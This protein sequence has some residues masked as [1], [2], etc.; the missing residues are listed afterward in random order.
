MAGEMH[1][2]CPP[3]WP[4]I[5]SR[6]LLEFI[7]KASFMLD[8]LWLFP[9]S[10]MARQPSWMYGFDVPHFNGKRRS[11]LAISLLFAAS[12]FRFSQ[13][14]FSLRDRIPW[15]YHVITTRYTQRINEWFH[16]TRMMRRHPYI[17]TLQCPWCLKYRPDEGREIPH[18]FAKLSS[19]TNK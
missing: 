15:A 16:F 1:C 7:W 10:G 14:Q 12:Y 8:P 4:N 9:L 19:V 13:Q 11:L 18:L 5:G 6:V 2:F 3:S 17:W